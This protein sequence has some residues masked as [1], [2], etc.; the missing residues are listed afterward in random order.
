MYYK[1]QRLVTLQ[2]TFAP[3]VIDL[4]Y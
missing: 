2:E 1:E 3:Q 4:F